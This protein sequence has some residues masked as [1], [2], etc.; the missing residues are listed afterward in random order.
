[1]LPAPSKRKVSGT[2]WKPSDCC[3]SCL[4]SASTVKGHDLEVTMP[5]PLP[6]PCCHQ[7][8]WPKVLL[9]SFFFH[10]GKFRSWHPALSCTVNTRMPK[11]D[12]DRIALANVILYVD[13]LTIQGLHAGSRK[14]LSPVK[15][16]IMVKARGNDCRFHFTL[17]C[18][19]W[20]TNVRR[21]LC[22]WVTIH[23][24]LNIFKLLSPISITPYNCCVQ[25]PLLENFY[26]YT[27][28]NN[29]LCCVNYSCP[30]C[31]FFRAF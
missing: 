18:W 24:K 30:F 4:V 7:W 23:Q 9:C 12:N 19:I 10:S 6:N 26:F 5:V 31:F 11:T 17:F 21:F 13:R 8:W 16:V 28:F 27:K 22:C 29:N 2:V 20:I 14:F 1:M 25:L 3:N 15:A